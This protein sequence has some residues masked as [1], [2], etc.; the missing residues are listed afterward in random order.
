MNSFRQELW[1]DVPA[2]REFRNIT[3]QVSNCLIESDIREGL[4]LVNAMHITSSAFIND[5]ESGLHNDFEAW[6]ENLAPY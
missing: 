3:P 4:L 5:D 1:F 6:L 2:R